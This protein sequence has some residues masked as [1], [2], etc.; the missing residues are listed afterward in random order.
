MTTGTC[1][2]ENAFGLLFAYHHIEDEEYA[3]ER[4]EFVKRFTAF[5][6]AI[7]EHAQA[8]PLGAGAV[9]FELGHALYFEIADGDQS[10]DLLAW[11]RAAAARLR[12]RD[13]VVTAVLT[14]GGRWIDESAR[15]LPRVSAPHPG[16]VLLR[17]TR[18]SEP[19]RRALYAE[20]ACHGGEGDDGWGPGCYV[21]EEAVAALSRTFQNSP[22]PLTVA[23]APFF[24]IGG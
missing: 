1:I 12:E 16:L 13:F 20:T 23:G 10:V 14:H 18:P 15:D 24:R 9:C 2:D 19:F 17:A 11:L 22:T 7:L 21:D 4:E 3:L 6:E 8:S 5:R